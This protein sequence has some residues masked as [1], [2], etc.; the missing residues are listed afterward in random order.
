MTKKGYKVE[1]KLKPEEDW[2]QIPKVMSV[3]FPELDGRLILELDEANRIKKRI[4]HSLGDY[5]TV[6]TRYDPEND[7]LK[8]LDQIAGQLP[9]DEPAYLRVTVKFPGTKERVYRAE[10]KWFY[11]DNTEEMDGF[12][13]YRFIVTRY[14]ESE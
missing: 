4:Y 6:E 12:A 5:L 13:L 2:I 8:K 10:Y 7:V 11:M 9:L 3:Q 1:F 14:M